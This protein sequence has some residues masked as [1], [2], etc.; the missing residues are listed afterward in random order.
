[1][2]DKHEQWWW[3]GWG[4]HLGIPFIIFALVATYNGV[5]S[6]HILTHHGSPERHVMVWGSGLLSPS[7]N[8]TAAALD[9]FL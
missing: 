8:K 5:D 9:Q 7:L 6:Q 1:M 3:W 4:M 2:H